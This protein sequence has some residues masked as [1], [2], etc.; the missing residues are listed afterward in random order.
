MK[1]VAVRR[2][3]EIKTDEIFG[4]LRRHCLNDK[5]FESYKSICEKVMEV[6]ENCFKIIDEGT[7]SSQDYIDLLFKLHYNVD[8]A[9]KNSKG[10]DFDIT[11]NCLLKIKTKIMEIPEWRQSYY[12]ELLTTSVFFKDFDESFK[13]FEKSCMYVESLET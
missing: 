13:D 6:E 2:E 12:D 7:L 9:W 8:H 4:I 11:R 5:K 1:C 10:V 3:Y